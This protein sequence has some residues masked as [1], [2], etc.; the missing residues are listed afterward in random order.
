MCIAELVIAPLHLQ[1]I[2]DPSVFA[3]ANPSA[4]DT[5]RGEIPI[6]LRNRLITGPLLSLAL[7]ALLYADEQLGSVVC[8]CCTPLQPGL[9][10]AALAM[11]IVPLVAIELGSIAN[12]IGLRC[13]I[14]LMVIS[15]WGWIGAIFL[16][17]N[18]METSTT[19]ALICTL[20]IASIAISVIALSKNRDLK[21]VLAGTTFT[22]ATSAYIAFGIGMFLLLRRDHSAWWIFGVVAVIKMC[23]TGAFFIGCNFGK[24]KLIP[25]ISPGKTWEGLLGGLATAALTAIG[26]A[27]AN[28]HWLQ[29]EP[30]IPL[31][32]AGA[33][34]LLFGFLGQAGDLVMSVFKRDSGIK[35]TS[36]VLPG[37]GG[38]LD[39]LDSLLLVGPV[40]Y[41]LLPSG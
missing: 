16:I 20:F 39:V 41:W 29:S 5:N 22:V 38:V 21:G 34:G 15:M 10:I 8:G 13:S 35:D 7:I 1:R 18:T 36:S 12:G 30:E 9:L 19:I 4:K 25:W 6:M 2:Y 37:L 28:N 33:V 14:P 17:P 24:H 40:A 31:L 23:D 26:L 27:A 11:A 32:T 3:N